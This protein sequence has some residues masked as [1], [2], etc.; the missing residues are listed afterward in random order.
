M[1][2][3]LITGKTKRCHRPELVRLITHGHITN[4]SARILIGD[5]S[6]TAD[7]RRKR[8]KGAEEPSG[9]TKH[10]AVFSCEK[11]A[12]RC[13]NFKSD[14]SAQKAAE[15]NYRHRPTPK[16]PKKLKSDKNRENP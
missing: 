16:S 2:T 6:E 12:E 10:L 15:R 4:G 9:R 7:Q 13:K 1:R 5:L 8:Q 14:F 11:S 3:A